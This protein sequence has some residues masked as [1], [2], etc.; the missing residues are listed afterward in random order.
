M[1]KKTVLAAVAALSLGGCGPRIDY[2]AIKQE[3]NNRPEFVASRA[4]R[5]NESHIKVH[6]FAGECPKVG[7]PAAAR[8]GQVAAIR[9]VSPVND[10]IKDKSGRDV[11]FITTNRSGRDTGSWIGQNAFGAKARVT[12]RQFVN[13]GLAVQLDDSFAGEGISSRPIRGVVSQVAHAASSWGGKISSGKALWVSGVPLDVPPFVASA[14]YEA[15]F[16]LPIEARHSYRA[17]QV[18]KLECAAAIDGVGVVVERL[19]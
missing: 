1:S 4:S 18:I 6:Q 15:T 9:A 17:D 12:T 19:Y 2:E 8:P 14:Y 16:D 11:W 3:V 7:E 5:S 10:T 13:T